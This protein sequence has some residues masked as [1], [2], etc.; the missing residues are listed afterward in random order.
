MTQNPAVDEI[1]ITPQLVDW[2]LWNLPAF[3]EQLSNMESLSS[4]SVVVLTHRRTGHG[5]AVERF[6]IERATITMVLDAVERAVRYLHPECRRVYRMK[7]VAGYRNSQ[8]ARRLFI[9]RRTLQR[10]LDTVRETVAQEL[11]KVPP[12]ILHDMLA[13]F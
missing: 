3:K 7:Y 8:I 5:S 6:A 1:E 4:T 11:R 9:S 10:R 12:R 2:L 13:H